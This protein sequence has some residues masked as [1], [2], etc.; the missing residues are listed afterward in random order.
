MSD[1]RTVVVKEIES[2]DHAKVYYTLRQV[3]VRLISDDTVR[4][5]KV[6]IALRKFGMTVVTTHMFHGFYGTTPANV[7]SLLH[8]LGDKGI[9]TLVK[10]MKPGVFRYCLSEKFWSLWTAQQSS[11]SSTQQSINT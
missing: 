4:A 7:V 6:F 11:S 10:N 9:L 8:R 1:V 2:I 3:H 5:V